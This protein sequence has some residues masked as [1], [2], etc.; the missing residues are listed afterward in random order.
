MALN[1]S[2]WDVVNKYIPDFLKNRYILVSIV[3]LGWMLLFDDANIF[4]QIELSNIEKR[5]EADV[6]YYEDKIQQAAEDRAALEAN[7][8]K[9]A[10]EKYYLK[11]KNEDVYIFE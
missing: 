8:E 3:F 2:P 7:Q 9:F 4:K 5:Y 11:K 10:R 6:I 1:Q